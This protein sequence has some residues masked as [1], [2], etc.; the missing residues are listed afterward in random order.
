[1]KRS[2]LFEDPV[3]ATLATSLCAAAPAALRGLRSRT[4][5]LPL[6]VTLHTRGEV[7]IIKLEPAQAPPPSPAIRSRRLSPCWRRC[8]RPGGSSRDAA[9]AAQVRATTGWNRIMTYQFLHD[10]SGKVMTE[11]KIDELESFFGLHFFAA[12]IPQQARELYRRNWLRLIPDVAYTPAPLVPAKADH[13][14][15]PLDMSRCVLCSVSPIHLEYLRNVGVNASMSLSIVIRNELWGLISCHH[16]TPRAMAV[17]LRAACELFV[18]I[19][20]LHLQAKIET[21]AAH[22]RIAPLRVQKAFAHRLPQAKDIAAELVRGQVTLLDLIP[23]SGAAV[24]LDGPHGDRLTP[25]KSF[26]AWQENVRQ[27]SVPWDAV[28]RRVA[29]AHQS[30]LMTELDHRVKNILVNIHAFVQQTKTRA[31]SPEDFLLSLELRIRAM[32][33][34]R[35]LIATTRWKGASVRHLVEEE[36]APFRRI[37]DEIFCIAGDDLMLSTGSAILFTIA[38]HE[39]VSNAAK[40]DALSRPAESIAIGWSQE[41]DDGALVLT[42]KERNGPP[43]TQPKRRG[44][45]SVVIDCSL[46]H[47]INGHCTLTFEANGVGCVITIPAGHVVVPEQESEACHD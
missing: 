34:V 13:G 22:R 2:D 38:V 21:E 40:Y 30:L 16:N 28:G 29:F 19:F 31:H 5:S 4:G 7:T 41:G 44:F 11:D 1:M 37:K 17:D 18:Q 20:S 26:V 42:W 12:N 8:N 23:A 36:L 46:R 27:P 14:G 25:R 43:V 10:G 3:L 9:A 15:P 39:L 24:W 6:D 33:N 45:G 32:V 35:S 47:E